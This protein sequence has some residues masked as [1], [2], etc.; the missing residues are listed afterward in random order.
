MIT[1]V[2]FFIPR[3]MML[4]SYGIIFKVARKQ[5]VQVCEIAQV[6]NT[7][8]GQTLSSGASVRKSNKAAKTLGFITSIF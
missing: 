1:I 8:H 2:A 5:E 3:L 7:I 6:A 4:T